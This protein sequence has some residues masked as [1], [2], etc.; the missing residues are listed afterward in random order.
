MDSKY[1]SE[2][3]TKF[4]NDNVVVEGWYWAL[5]SRELKTGKAKAVRLSGKD[6]AVFR[7]ES[8]KVVAM[9]AFCPHR[10]AHLGGGTVEGEALRCYYH[11]WKFD[12]TGECVDVPCLKRAPKTSVSTYPAE[13][14]Y[15]LIWVW[16]GEGEPHGLPLIPG[17]ENSEAEVTFA[18]PYVKNCHPNIVMS[19]AIDVQHFRSVHRIPG[20][21]LDLDG[22]QIDGHTL[23]YANVAGVPKDTLIGNLIALFYKHQLTYS[24]CYWNGSSGSVT[25]GPDFQ[26]FHI[27]YAN[28]LG[29][30]GVSEGQVVLLTKK[31]KTAIG[32]FYSKSLLLATRIVSDYFANGDTPQFDT[33]KFDFKTPI[34]DDKTILQFINHVEQSPV[35]EWGFSSAKN[36]NKKID[37]IAVSSI[38]EEQSAMEGD[39]LCAAY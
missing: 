25:V 34:K 15:G 30:N 37:R 8:G 39:E 17:L 35:A 5:Q 4:N 21:I 14:H 23:H 1:S 12:E 22:Q 28:R 29:D 26:Q 32:R 10:G 2:K 18:K 6:L 3:L 9:D 16:V 20:D 13:D 27:I 7:T 24:L 38:E 31:R 19:D 33:I 11:H 36:T